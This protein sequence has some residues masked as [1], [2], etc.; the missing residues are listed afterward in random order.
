MDPA[1]VVPDL[2]GAKE[3][4]VIPFSA[5]V[6]T[7]RDPARDAPGAAGAAPMDAALPTLL[8]RIAPRPRT[9]R[10]PP[11]GKLE[12]ALRR[13]DEVHRLAKVRRD[14]TFIRRIFETGEYPY[15]E[16][17]RA[18][19]YAHGMGK[20]QCELLKCQRWVQE[21]GRKIVVLFEGR[22]AAGKGSTIKRFTEHMSPRSARV[23]ALTKPTERE[24]TQWYL[25]RFAGHLPAAGEICLFDRSWY[26][27]A[28]V[29]WVMGFCTLKEY[30]EFMHQCPLFEH[31]LTRSEIHLFKYWFSVTR[32]EQLRRIKARELDPLKR[33]KLSA[34][35][36]AAIERWDEY[37]QAKE[38]MFCQTDTPFAPWIVIKSDDKRRARIN[39]MRHFLHSL[40]YPGK[41]SAIVT[42]ADP[43][44]VGT[45]DYVVG[46]KLARAAQG[47]ATSP[48]P[49]RTHQRHFR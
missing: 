40:P 44:I 33:W 47:E 49:Y 14:P 32:H 7:G 29:E 25:Q 23:V 12:S 42:S 2:E 45:A 22:D 21:T 48:Y 3:S 30:L 27:R 37:T 11:D 20:L 31:M 9:L 19:V 4:K 34:N 35:D 1:L 46:R 15:Q 6:H 16:N 13:I 36:Y 38:A 5:G 10:E 18:D 17:M 8:P 26:N 41:E 39:C 43:L 28:G 24:Q